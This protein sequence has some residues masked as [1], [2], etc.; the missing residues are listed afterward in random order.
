MNKLTI[1]AIV[2]LLASCSSDPKP[3]D[4][5]GTIDLEKTLP[6]T[7]ESVSLRVDINTAEGTDTSFV[8][9][10][11]EEEWIQRLGVK[12]VKTYFKPDNKYEQIFTSL[13]DTIL[14]TSRGMWNIFGDTL[15]MVEPNAT[16]QYE[17]TIENGL[18]SL[19]ARLDWD[20]DG[21]EDDDYLG[22]HRK[23]STAT[24]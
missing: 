14:S 11:R 19:K 16:Y 15:M 10:V 17:A 4:S 24:N 23:V 5:T 22:V 6:G 2:L 12:P 18:I 1:F 13:T 3:N 21:E 8:F 9:E 7:W 20:G